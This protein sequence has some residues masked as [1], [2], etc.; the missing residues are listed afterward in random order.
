MHFWK[1]RINEQENKAELA[2]TSTDLFLVTS[3]ISYIVAVHLKRASKLPKSYFDSLW[4]R[5]V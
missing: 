2:S 3:I 5:N 1:K 4:S